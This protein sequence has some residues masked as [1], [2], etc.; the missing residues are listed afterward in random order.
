MKLN[1]LKHRIMIKNGAIFGLLLLLGYACSKPQTN[2][3]TLTGDWIGD[4]IQLV[5]DIV[6]ETVNWEDALL[7]MYGTTV[8]F[9]ADSLFTLS[10]FTDSVAEITSGKWHMPDKDRLLVYTDTLMNVPSRDTFEF[11]VDKLTADGY[12]VVQAMLD[13][14]AVQAVFRR[15]EK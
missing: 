11:K 10:T 4:T 7:Q 12:V 13:S 1:L 6:P 15:V 2:V 8:Q 5:S 3:P 14:L 9:T